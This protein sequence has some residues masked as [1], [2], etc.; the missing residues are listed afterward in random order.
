MSEHYTCPRCEIEMNQFSADVGLLAKIVTLYCPSCGFQIKKRD[1]EKIMD[2]GRSEVRQ[3][4]G[5]ESDGSGTKTDQSIHEMI[6][7]AKNDMKPPIGCKPYY[8]SISA[9]V[10]ELCEAIKRYLTE[11]GGH[12]QIKLWLKELWDLNEMD[13]DLRYEEKRKVWKED[14]DG[15]LQE[16]P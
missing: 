3:I 2:I 13:R 5:K 11:N 6:F 1:Y 14:K 9:R 15:K 4:I 7:H 10:C 16:M 8:V 12:N